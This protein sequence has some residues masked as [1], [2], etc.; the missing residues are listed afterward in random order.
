[1]FLLTSIF[2]KIDVTLVMLKRLF[3]VVWNVVRCDRKLVMPCIYEVMDRVGE[4]IAANFNNQ[5]K[6][7]KGVENN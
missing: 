5:N 4:Q 6:L 7:S 2:S 1:M 3:L